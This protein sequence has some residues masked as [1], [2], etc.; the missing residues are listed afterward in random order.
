MRSLVSDPE[1]DYIRDDAR[2]TSMRAEVEATA[3]RRMK[4]GIKQRIVETLVS[5][6]RDEA[7]KQVVKGG[8][9]SSSNPVTSIIN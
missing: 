7:D 6:G 9:F 4:T 1:K 5:R 2:A 8:F 3:P